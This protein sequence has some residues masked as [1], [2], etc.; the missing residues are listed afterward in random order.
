MTRRTFLAALAPAPRPNVLF[1]GVDDLNTCLS[2][3][4]HPLVKTPNIDRIAKAGVR[5][6][7]AYTQYPFCSPSRTSLMTGLSPDATGVYNL[8]S[9][10]KPLL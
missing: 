7:K 10:L 2:C 1:I 4:G 8:T 9:A 5:F 3:Y 6:D